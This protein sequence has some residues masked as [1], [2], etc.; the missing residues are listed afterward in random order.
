[1]PQWMFMGGAKTAVDISALGISP[2][3]EAT[4]QAQ[5]W[6][7]LNSDGMMPGRVRKKS[8]NPTSLPV[9]VGS[10]NPLKRFIQPFCIGF[11]DQ[12]ESLIKIRDSWLKPEGPSPSLLVY[13]DA[14]YYAL[15]G[16]I[17]PF[18]VSN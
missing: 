13:V 1:M 2:V 18:S 5:G 8:E 12:S 15:Q 16:Y 17:S 3:K 11:Q 10:L 6:L 4:Y 14:S 7:G 9:G